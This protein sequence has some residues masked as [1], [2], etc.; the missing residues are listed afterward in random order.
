MGVGGTSL[1]IIVQYIIII[2]MYIIVIVP[3]F[4]CNVS[5]PVWCSSRFPC[6]VIDV[7]VEDKEGEKWWQWTAPLFESEKDTEEGLL[8][9]K[10]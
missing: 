6:L 10:H 7:N 5:V 3:V 1:F 9:C 8:V 2:C 4:F